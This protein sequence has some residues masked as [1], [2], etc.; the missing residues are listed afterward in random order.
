MTLQVCHGLHSRRTHQGSSPTTRIV[1]YTGHLSSL[2]KTSIPHLRLS[3]ASRMRSRRLERDARPPAP[4]IATVV[5][6]PKVQERATRGKGLARKVERASVFRW[7]KDADG[8]GD[9]SGRNTSKSPPICSSRRSRAHRATVS[10]PP[11]CGLLSVCHL[12]SR[13]E[14]LEI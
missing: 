4:S 11:R 13:G 5:T 9:T 2:S 12:F 3:K 6:P 14:D 8:G 7:N 1:P 10:L